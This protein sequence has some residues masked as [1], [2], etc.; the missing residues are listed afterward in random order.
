LWR[1][2]NYALRVRVYSVR[3]P[4]TDLDVLRRVRY[5]TRAACD[6]L[7]RNLKRR[8]AWRSVYAGLG[9]STAGR[10][11]SG[12]VSSTIDDPATFRELPEAERRNTR[13]QI[14][15]RI[16]LQRAERPWRTANHSNACR[17]AQCAG[18]EVRYLRIIVWVGIFQKNKKLSAFAVEQ[19]W[20]DVRWYVSRDEFRVRM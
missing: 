3:V 14:R 6:V 4:H 5:F 7:S 1:F 10:R 17:E 19:G 9:V 18:G 15:N 13:R 16:G 11:K 8:F 2:C 12:G 20:R